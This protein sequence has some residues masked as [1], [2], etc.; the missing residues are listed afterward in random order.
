V[1]TIFLPVLLLFFKRKTTI[2]RFRGNV[3]A[4]APTKY[5]T[6][7][8]KLEKYS[9]PLEKFSIFLIKLMGVCFPCFQRAETAQL[10]CGDAPAAETLKGPGNA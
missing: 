8:K 10:F 1:F 9:F 4:G 6:D 5:G 3:K 7:E 2:H